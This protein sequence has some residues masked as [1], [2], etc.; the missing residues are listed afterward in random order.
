MTYKFCLLIID[1]PIAY[2][3]VY[4]I[5]RRLNEVYSLSKN[6]LLLSPNDI[7]ITAIIKDPRIFQGLITRRNILF[8]PMLSDVNLANG[9]VSYNSFGNMNTISLID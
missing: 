3:I 9:R 7:T 4:S 8:V 6:P 2:S 5:Y 1:R